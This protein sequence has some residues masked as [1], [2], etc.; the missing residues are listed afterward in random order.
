MR[1]AHS[2]FEWASSRASEPCTTHTFRTGQRRAARTLPCRRPPSAERIDREQHGRGCQWPRQDGLPFLRRFRRWRRLYNRIHAALAH[3][4]TLSRWQPWETG[5]LD[6]WG[7]RAVYLAGFDS[8]AVGS[9]VL[10]S[11]RIV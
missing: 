11:G 7:M 8:I 1:C 5:G 2:C 9:I 6:R 10:D 4:G 3:V